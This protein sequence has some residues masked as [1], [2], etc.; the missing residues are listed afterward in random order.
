MPLPFSC[1]KRIFYPWSSWVCFPG[2]F[3]CP[4]C[5][6]SF[7]FGFLG[8]F[9][10]CSG[11]NPW[12]WLW[13]SS[14]Y[15]NSKKSSNSKVH[16]VGIFLYIKAVEFIFFYYQITT[17]KH[18]LLTEDFFL[19]TLNYIAS[20]WKFYFTFLPFLFSILHC[21]A[22]EMWYQTFSANMSHDRNKKQM[23]NRKWFTGSQGPYEIDMNR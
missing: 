10:I 7:C 4:S 16:G 6:C 5:R 15:M 20:F 17:I 14:L 2:F 11:I 19:K 13:W 3:L 22:E 18:I 23:D 9:W 12:S 1:L 8:N 21:S